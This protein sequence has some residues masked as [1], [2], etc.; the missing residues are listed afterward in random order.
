MIDFSTDA[1]IQDG[2]ARIARIKQLEVGRGLD[3]EPELKI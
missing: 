3:E 2:Y 1:R